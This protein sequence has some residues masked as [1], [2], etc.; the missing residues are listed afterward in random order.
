MNTII[1]AISKE[2][3]KMSNFCPLAFLPLWAHFFPSFGSNHLL[4]IQ[5]LAAYTYQCKEGPLEEEIEPE[6]EEM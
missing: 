1:P 6:E 4:P 3:L 5:Q 2:A